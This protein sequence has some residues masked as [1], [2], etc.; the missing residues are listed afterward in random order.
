M[1]MHYR[2]EIERRKGR[3]ER[4]GE[5]RRRKGERRGCVRMRVGKGIISFS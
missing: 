4:G 1:Y 3:E 2:G 5:V